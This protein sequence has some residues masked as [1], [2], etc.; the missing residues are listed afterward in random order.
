MKN[1]LNKLSQHHAIDTVNRGSHFSHAFSLFI[2]R[3]SQK[4]AETTI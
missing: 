4:V 2:I 3:T 1:A